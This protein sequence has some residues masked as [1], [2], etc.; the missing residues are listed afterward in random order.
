MIIIPLYTAFTF[1]RQCYAKQC[2]TTTPLRYAK[3]S[4]ITVTCEQKKTF[5]TKSL[6]SWGWWDRKIN[7]ILK[8]SYF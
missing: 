3:Q 2:V 4:S 8:T 5:V 7:I 6:E 1:A